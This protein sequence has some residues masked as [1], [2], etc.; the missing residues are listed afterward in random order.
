ML[1]RHV[2]FALAGCAAIA[3]CASGDGP[4]IQIPEVEAT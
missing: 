4:A 1:I 3:R 2:A